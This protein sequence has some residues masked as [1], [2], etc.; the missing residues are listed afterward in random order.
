MAYGPFAQVTSDPVAGAP[1]SAINWGALAAAAAPY[2]VGGIGYM[3]QQ[4]TN[5]SNAK[6]AASTNAFNA[7][8]AELNRKFQKEMSDSAY[9]RA[10][11]D[12]EAAGLNPALAYQQGGAHSG[13]GSAASGV[14]AKFDSSAGA[15]INS[16]MAASS[17]A[18]QLANVKKTEAETGLTNEQARTTA[19]MRAASLAELQ[20]RATVNTANAAWMGTQNRNLWDSFNRRMR[21]L[22]S[23]IDRNVASASEV[24]SKIPLNEANTTLSRLSIPSARNQANMA[25][26]WMGKNVFPYLQGAESLSRILNGIKPYGIIGK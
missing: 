5:A 1:G 14:S 9:Q 20:T 15:G 8:Q 3:G 10:V 2:V 21:L 23:E 4:S 12:L 25:E 19:V 13:S 16:A 6:Q 17:I 24:R 18:N 26:T 11:K 7:Q 22:E